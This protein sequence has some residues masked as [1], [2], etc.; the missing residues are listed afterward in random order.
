MGAK[1]YQRLTRAIRRGDEGGK[2]DELIDDECGFAIVV[3][4]I[5]LCR[6]THHDE[7]GCTPLMTLERFVATMYDNMDFGS[8]TYMFDRDSVVHVIGRLDH[9]HGD[10]AEHEDQLKG[11]KDML[12]DCLNRSEYDDG[13]DLAFY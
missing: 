7:A 3:N 2:Y 11:I 12:K 5:Y 8:E 6:A 4:D 10:V 1:A 13:F 9:V